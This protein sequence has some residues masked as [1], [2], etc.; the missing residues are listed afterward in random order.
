MHAYI[1]NCGLPFTL[2]IRGK[3]V[4]A[5]VCKT[6]PRPGVATGRTRGRNMRSRC[7]CSRY[8]AIHINSRSWLR[9]SSTH[10]PSDPP[11]RVVL[12]DVQQML[13]IVISIKTEGSSTLSDRIVHLQKQK[14][15]M[16][17]TFFN[18]L[19]VCINYMHK[20]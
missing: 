16:Q 8:P 2:H 1:Y 10:E 9:S 20:K 17:V 18:N 14:I 19:T 15:A 5:I 13:R 6:D 4:V 3:K 11:L 7:R 12:Y